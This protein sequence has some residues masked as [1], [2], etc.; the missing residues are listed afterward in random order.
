MPWDCSLNKD[1]DDAFIVHCALTQELHDDDK[2]KFSSSTQP[3]LEHSYARLLSSNG[4]VGVGSPSSKRIVEDIMKCVGPNMIAI[5]RARGACIQGLGD[6]KGRRSVTFA[7][8]KRGGHRV[9][10]PFGSMPWLHPDAE[11]ARNDLLKKSIA[12]CDGTWENLDV[13]LH[14]VS[15]S[16]ANGQLAPG[17]V[18]LCL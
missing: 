10:K 12:I 6:R 8:N 17:E 4:G 16:E 9:K 18:E 5:V 7:N 14:E 2:K 1:L 13:Q 15:L 11:A 3:Q